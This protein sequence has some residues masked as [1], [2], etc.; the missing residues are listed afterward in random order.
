MKN[1]LIPAAILAA[2]LALSAPANAGPGDPGW[3]GNNGPCNPQPM[4]NKW[5]S[6]H[7]VEITI[8]GP[9]GCNPALPFANN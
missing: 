5:S 1:L 6:D 2:P 8:W 9:Q 4:G 3:Y 7:R